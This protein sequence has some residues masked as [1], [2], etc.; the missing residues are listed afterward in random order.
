LKN[1]INSGKTQDSLR[2]YAIGSS[3][4]GIKQKL[5]EN[6]KLSKEEQKQSA[7][8]QNIDQSTMK[9]PFDSVKPNLEQQKAEKSMVEEQSRSEKTTVKETMRA[10]STLKAK[11]NIKESL[12]TM[13]TMAPILGKMAGYIKDSWDQTFPKDKFQMKAEK[14][15]RKARELAE[16]EK[17]DHVEYS[18]EELEK[19]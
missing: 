13:T 19:V 1:Q 5:Y 8:T 2:K 9:T 15:K 4:E 16:R 17:R 7:K 11:L 6:F 18:E 14:V 3:F 10:R 12:A